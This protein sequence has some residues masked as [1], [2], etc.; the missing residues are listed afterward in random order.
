MPANTQFIWHAETSE[1][2]LKFLGSESTRGLSIEEARKRLQEVGPNRLTATKTVSPW[3]VFFGQFKN[4]LVI[5]LLIGIVLS[6][7]LGH[8]VEAIAIGVIVLFAVILGFVQEFRA[9]KAM[10][11]LK[12]MAAPLATI[13]RAGQEVEVA[14][15]ELVPGDI[16]VLAAGDRIAADA[17]ILE[18]IN[19][20]AE[21]ASLTG[22]SVPV[23]KH[24]EVI[25]NANTALGDRKNMLFAST[26]ISYGRGLAVVVETGM[27]TEIGKIAGMLQDV[28]STETP[29][30]KNLDHVGKKL[31][32]AAFVIVAV[33]V[34]VGLFRGSPLVEILL[35]GVALAVAVVPEALPAVVT[36]SLSIGVQRM[37]KRQALVRRLSAVETLGATTVICT[38]KTGTLT[39]DE[40]TI[41]KI[42]LPGRPIVDVTGAGYQPVGDFL[43]GDKPVLAEG[44]FLEFLKAGALCADAHLIENEEKQWD[45]KG[46]PT[47]GALVVAAAKA[48]LIKSELDSEYTRVAEIPFSSED[49]YM[50]TAHKAV[51][52]EVQYV[53]GAAEVVLDFCTKFASATSTEV[54]DDAQRKL[55]LNQVHAFSNQALRVIALAY[56][57]GIEIGSKPS[58]LVFLGL[59]AMIDPPR[60]EAEQAIATSKKAGIKVVMITGDHPAT[61]EAI[62]R[63]LGL[64][65]STG[66]VLTGPELEKMSDADLAGKIE[67]IDVY[68]RVSPEHKLRIVTALQTKGHVVAMTGDGV[69]DAPALKKADIGI[70]MGIT[71]TDVAKEA[72]DMLLLDD[73]FAS[74]VAAIEEG[75]VI[76]GNIKKYLTY[77][78]S[79]NI[80]EIGL[81]A[82]ATLLGLPLPLTAVQILYVNLATDGLPALALAVDPPRKNL[83]SEKPRNLKTG[84][85]T[86][87]VVALMLTGGIWSTILNVSLFAFLRMS[88]RPVSEVMTIVFVNLVLVE[89]VKAYAFR[90]ESVSMFH[91]FFSNKWLNLA[92]LWELFLL[93]VVVYLPVLHQAFTT[94]A[95][96]TADLIIILPSVLTVVLV[97]E[98]AKLF[99]NKYYDHKLLPAKL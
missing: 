25:A 99:I 20:K 33:I 49:K 12:K 83:M 50:A 35:F 23:Q 92:V 62:A 3:S 84:L 93:A 96:T 90:S 78:L 76:F 42:Y 55:V 1:E 37:V 51:A 87:P 15:E 54:M 68:A 26:N 6:G 89:F 65:N 74:I 52:R 30:Q 40:M 58:D 57:D 64:I 71:G 9:E 98:V 22:E 75:R 17:R 79:S 85:F 69:N 61:A 67:S 38:D 2:V 72:A 47:E 97:L 94:F 82:G 31:A 43:A 4:I 27:N 81:M 16:L 36:I 80:G 86:K 56:K 8:L 10:E 41:R 14:A 46:D 5:I 88:G 53:K 63:E 13:L 24:S 44:G 28:V 18:S 19:L 95:L 60:A 45:I 39:K 11:A 77:L 34:A 7:L 21:E 66:F 29:L 48:G 70:A 91:N 59:A 32:Q 73:N